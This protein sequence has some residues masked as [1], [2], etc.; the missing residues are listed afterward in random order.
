MSD[1]PLFLMY[2][3]TS[4][5]VV[6]C[7]DLSEDAF[8]TCIVGQSLTNLFPNLNSNQLKSN[9]LNE[10]C[11]LLLGNPVQWS[12]VHDTG[13]SH[14][15]IGTRHVPSWLNSVHQIH[16]VST[17]YVC[18]KCDCFYLDDTIVHQLQLHND[19]NYASVMEDLHLDEHKHMWTDHCEKLKGN[20]DIN[21]VRYY[22]WLK[23][24]DWKYH[25]AEVC[26]CESGHALAGSITFIYETFAW[27]LLDD[28]LNRI[29]YAIAI[30][31]SPTDLCYMNSAMMHL[32]KIEG[33]SSERRTLFEFLDHETAEKALQQN[34]QLLQGD[35]AEVKHKSTGTLSDGKTRA[36]V[37][38]Q[39][40]LTFDHFLLFLGEEPELVVTYRSR[41]LSSSQ[42]L[43]LLVSVIE[44]V[45]YL[46]R[47]GIV[48]FSDTDVIFCN[49]RISEDFRVKPYE[50]KSS[51]QFLEL[52]CQAF[53]NPQHAGSVIN[54]DVDDE[55]F[56]IHPRIQLK[57]GRFVE[58]T[59]VQ[60]K[61]GHDSV[62]ILVVQDI[63]D[64][65]LKEKELRVARNS[66]VE[67]NRS[68]SQFLALMSHNLFTPLTSVLSAA[69]ALEETQPTDSSSIIVEESQKLHDMLQN[70]VD[71]YNFPSSPS[72][73]TTVQR[74]INLVAITDSLVDLLQPKTSGLRIYLYVDPRCD[75]EVSTLPDHFRKIMFILVSNSL[76]YT[77]KGY[78]KVKMVC[79][80]LTDTGIDIFCEV[81]DSGIGIDKET[82]RTLFQDFRVGDPTQHEGMGVGLALSNKLAKELGTHLE[83]ESRLGHGSRFHFTLSATRPKLSRTA[84]EYIAI[85]QDMRCIIIARDTTLLSI[86][87]LSDQ[88]SMLSCKVHFQDS[89]DSDLLEDV[90][91]QQTPVVVFIESHM[92]HVLEHPRIVSTFR[93]VLV[94]DPKSGVEPVQ[95]FGDNVISL[96]ATYS[97]L[98]SKL[99]RSEQIQHVIEDP[100]LIAG[101]WKV[102]VV[103]DCPMILKTVPKLLKVIGCSEVFTAS[104]GPEALV[105]Y[106]AKHQEISLVL[107]DYRMKPWNG[108]ETTRRIRDYE[109]LHRLQNSSIVA[110]TA[111][112]NLETMNACLSVCDGFLEK[113]VKK[114]RLIRVLNSHFARR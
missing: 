70:I 48:L 100:R 37:K 2:S 101:D 30:H 17:F 39:K 8:E 63:T 94:V 62:R 5:Q 10:S 45:S 1:D 47:V 44:D 15:A 4:G 22:T 85:L 90:V 91:Q 27:K 13:D 97:S 95:S 103:D 35:I 58:L 75:V 74:S 24:T 12:V 114:E 72:S 96:P 78:I 64:W 52:L 6:H 14:F 40:S 102:L 36:Q 92:A 33:N 51:R 99:L 60:N 32:S 106:A 9:G 34:R 81:S 46:T 43:H 16:H 77:E 89:E 29:P 25:L 111:D 7:N 59:N 67:Y 87:H 107:M 82:I 28:I 23:G 38:M 71:L 79:R 88:L 11:S 83:V 93:I 55:S 76:K 105:V 108:V 21:L 50:S 109:S 56:K 31:Q 68:R 42:K 80:Q 69:Q 20:P 18:N 26:I 57:T 49:K 41:C 98:L 3:T 84:P 61:C 53:L 110:L 113:P 65:I 86:Q 112:L 104:S 73:P 66:A 19:T 54:V